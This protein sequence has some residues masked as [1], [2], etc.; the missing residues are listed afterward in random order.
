MSRIGFA[1]SGG[2]APPDIVE[3][4]QR[5]VGGKRRLLRRCAPVPRDGDGFVL[6]R[7][8]GKCLT[9]GLCSVQSEHYVSGRGVRRPPRR[10]RPCNGVWRD[11]SGLGQLFGGWFWVTGTG[12]VRGVAA[13]GGGL[14]YEL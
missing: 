9:T 2:L 4:V 12:S 5:A 8:A 6:S 14:L 11:G 13:K 7:F 10:C 3:C 1:L